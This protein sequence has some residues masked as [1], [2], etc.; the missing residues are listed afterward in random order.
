MTTPRVYNLCHT[1]DCC[2]AVEV[3]EDHVAIGEDGNRVVLKPQEWE[4][5]RQGILRGEL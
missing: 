5:L 4:A 3:H 2:P 1:A